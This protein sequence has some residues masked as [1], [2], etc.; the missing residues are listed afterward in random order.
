M[1]K[2]PFVF[3]RQGDPWWHFPLNILIVFIASMGVLSAVLFIAATFLASMLA[4]V[5]VFAGM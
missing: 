1:F 4:F 3:H 5:F 2:L